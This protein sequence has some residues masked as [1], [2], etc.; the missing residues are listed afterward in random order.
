MVKQLGCWVKSAITLTIASNLAL[1]GCATCTAEDSEQRGKSYLKVHAGSQTAFASAAC[2]KTLEARDRDKPDVEK[3]IV[4]LLERAPR[5]LRRCGGT[6][7][8][9]LLVSYEAGLGVCIDCDNAAKGTRSAF[10]LLSVVDPAGKELAAAEWQDWRG[11]S[12][13][14]IA[15]RFV[16][17]LS[18]LTSAVSRNR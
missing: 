4:D 5:P 15:R 3:F 12:P 9:E 6:E 16:S 10:A 14:A 7:A 2:I 17:A 18:D 1:A 11:G 8:A 13:H